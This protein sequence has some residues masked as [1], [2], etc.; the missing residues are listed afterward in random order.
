MESANATDEPAWQPYVSA[1]R[2]DD[3]KQPVI[4]TRTQ[5]WYYKTPGTP[6]T[7]QL[8]ANGVCGGPSACADKFGEQ[9][10]NCGSTECRDLSGW[11][12]IKNKTLGTI[13]PDRSVFVFEPDTGLP[14]GCE[15]LC[16]RVS[17]E[18]QIALEAAPML[19]APRVPWTEDGTEAQ[20]NQC[21]KY[22]ETDSN[23]EEPPI[24]FFNGPGCTG[25]MVVFRPCRT[26]SSN[27]VPNE[28]RRD[29]PSDCE[30]VSWIGSAPAPVQSQFGT[31][32]PPLSFY[33]DT[34]LTAYRQGFDFER[35]RPEV[36]DNPHMVP[37]LQPEFGGSFFH[38]RNPTSTS[39]IIPPNMMLK[40]FKSGYYQPRNRKDGTWENTPGLVYGPGIY[41]DLDK[42]SPFR[43]SQD[44]N[45]FRVRRFKHWN[46]FTKDCCNGKGDARA[47][48][49]LSEKYGRPCVDKMTT[50]C[51]GPMFFTP[52]CE[53]WLSS[54]ESQERNVIAREECNKEGLT[55]QQKEW[56]SCFITRDIPPEFANDAVINAYWPCLNQVCNDSSRSLQ[57]FG[58]KCPGSIAVCNNRDFTAA[59]SKSKVGTLKLQNECGNINIGTGGDKPSPTG[60]SP[61]DGTSSAS[62]AW[63][64]YAIIVALILGIAAVVG[65]FLLFR[66]RKQ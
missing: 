1:S 44:D 40:T 9:W 22:V 56:C 24:R 15:P 20:I 27:V 29:G 8:D 59:L 26:G 16:C 50:T 41:G 46:R 51:R 34:N 13:P 43:W 11:A 38:R 37:Q 39:M 54:Y 62:P 47:C 30:G 23:S 64:T 53:E 25:G 48:A 57:R 18:E 2:T 3:Q 10:K 33:Y 61:T 5:Q 14:V 4:D 55:D 36:V 63:T 60:P 21:R 28:K 49:S 58:G 45:A 32:P 12:G 66:Q 52:E 42:E 65:Q 31:P 17:V 19:P 35:L 7:K 6:C